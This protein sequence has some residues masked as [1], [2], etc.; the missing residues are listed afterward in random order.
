[1]SD[2]PIDFAFDAAALQFAGTYALVCDGIELTPE[3]VA[4]VVWSYL[5]SL[6]CDE[7]R[8]FSAPMIEA[9][10]AFVAL[11][12]ADPEECASLIWERT[13]KD[14]LELQLS[15]FVEVAA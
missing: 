6:S 4:D 2:L 1:M 14:M 7:D 9:K 15:D 8:N 12:A 13:M 3:Q 11:C 10:A 5:D